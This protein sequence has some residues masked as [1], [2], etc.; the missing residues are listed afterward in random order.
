[1]R[2][3]AGL[4]T[5]RSLVFGAVML[6]GA[7]RVHAQ[8]GA[9]LN[10]E[11]AYDLA[12]AGQIILLDIRRPDEWLYTGSGAG[13]HRLDMRRPDFTAALDG[14][15][16]GDRSRPVALIC[17]RGVRSKRMADRLRAAGFSGVLDVP[18]GMLGSDA[19]IGWI[20]LGLPLVK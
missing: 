9:T 2:R 1:M 14:L 20:E 4:I 10:V 15:L 11:Q 5:R 16:D 8:D 3:S 19:G 12:A 6:C 13:A 17:A 7:P 18:E